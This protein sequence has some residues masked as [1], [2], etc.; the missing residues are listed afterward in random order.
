MKIKC[1]CKGDCFNCIYDDCIAPYSLINKF[2]KEQHEEAK[3]NGAKLFDKHVSY[4]DVMRNEFSLYT[5]YCPID[6]EY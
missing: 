4:S 6:T 5:G 1:E 3:G 2:N